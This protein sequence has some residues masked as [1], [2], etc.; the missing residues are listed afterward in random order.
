MI[1]VQ[2]IDEATNQQV[3]F[4]TEICGDGRRFEDQCDDGYNDPDPN[5]VDGCSN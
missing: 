3:S 1:D 5:A 2:I 4:C